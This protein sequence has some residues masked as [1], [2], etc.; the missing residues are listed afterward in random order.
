MKTRAVSTGHGYRTD[1]TSQDSGH[2]G[3]ASPDYKDDQARA[4][5]GGR[6][7]HGT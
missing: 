5:K 2:V 3:E 7:D 6:L 4:L 1:I